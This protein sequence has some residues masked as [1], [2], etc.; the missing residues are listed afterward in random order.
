[1]AIIIRYV[2]E[3]KG[4]EKFV[5]ADKKEADKYDKMLDL[6]DNLSEYIEAKG[7][8]IEGSVLEELGI[9]L[10]KNS[11]A[12]AKLLKGATAEQVL[13]EDSAEVITLDKKKA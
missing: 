10:A 8:A 11:G 7:L 12:L 4:V 2:V 5:T 1:M 6:A 13:A 9:M 3:H